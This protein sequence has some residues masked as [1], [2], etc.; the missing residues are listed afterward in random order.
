MTTT[1]AQSPSPS[2]TSKPRR[3]RAARRA[4]D[5]LIAHLIMAGVKDAEI[6]GAVGVSPRHYRRIIASSGFHEMFLTVEHAVS[7]AM[8]KVIVAEAAAVL[9]G[10]GNYGQSILPELLRC[11]RQALLQ[12]CAEP[13]IT[14]A[15]Q[16]AS[17]RASIGRAS[18]PKG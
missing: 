3:T 4:R 10:R 5:L 16:R 2:P 15:P 18:V 8:S 12:Q 17:S 11:S 9:V 7:V 14:G 1:T 6:R 13:E